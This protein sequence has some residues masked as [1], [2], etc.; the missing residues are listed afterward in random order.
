[1]VRIE[2]QTQGYVADR[3][4]WS[5]PVD[6]S[7]TEL[8][9]LG[10]TAAAVIQQQTKGQYP[11]PVAALETMLGAVEADID[12]ACQMEAEGMSHLFGS[13]INAA[14][15]NVFFLTDR[16]KK[17]RGIDVQGIEPQWVAT[18]AVIGAGIMGQGIAAANVKRHVPVTSDRC[19][20]RRVGEGCDQH[21]G[22]SVLQPAAWQGRCPS[23][24]CRW[25]R[26]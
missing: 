8:G 4:K 24:P 7:E 18:A 2:Q 22:R 9:F 21:P 10:A 25:R 13:P 26:C 1:M 14:L 3:E 16:N 17:D 23:V 5:G 20:S 19:Q 11:A 12:T 6:I 15:L